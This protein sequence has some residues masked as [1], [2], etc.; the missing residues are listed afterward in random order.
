M[1]PQIAIT[2]NIEQ[3][4]L[5]FMSKKDNKSKVMSFYNNAK[6]TASPQKESPLE[7]FTSS[8]IEGS[9]NK[10]AVRKSGMQG[11][12][13]KYDELADLAK[14]DRRKFFT[15]A[16][17]YGTMLSKDSMGLMTEA[18]SAYGQ[19]TESPLANIALEIQTAS[20]G[21]PLDA[22][23][24]NALKTNTPM[25][26]AIETTKDIPDKIKESINAVPELLDAFKKGV[27]GERL[28]Q[29]GDVYRNA[30]FPEPAA[31]ALGF[32][33]AALLDP[34]NLKRIPLEQA[35]AGIDD[36]AKAIVRASKKAKV[37]QKGVMDPQT[38]KM[39]VPKGKL[40]INYIERGKRIKNMIRNK[41]ANMNEQIKLQADDAINS[42]QKESDDLINKLDDATG[43]DAIETQDN[44]LKWQ[45][46]NSQIYGEYV[47]KI[48]GYM[49]KKGKELRF[50]DVENMTNE[51]FTSLQKEGRL[52]QGKGLDALTE[53]MEKYSSNGRTLLRNK[54]INF[55]EFLSDY[56]RVKNSIDI[57]TLTGKLTPES[58]PAETFRK[59][60]STFIDT[61]APGWKALNQRYAAVLDVTEKA[62]HIFKQGKGKYFAEQGQKFIQS[63]A[64]DAINSIESVFVDDLE[65]GI[66]GFSSGLGDIAKRS[67]YL[68][69]KI[70][71]NKARIGEIKEY[72]RLLQRTTA[73]GR[74][75]AIQRAD[76]KKYGVFGAKTLDSV[77]KANIVKQVAKRVGGVIGYATL[78][79]L[80]NRSILRNIIGSP[81]YNN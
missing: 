65:K 33:T 36:A 34:L 18:L 4:V 24:E 43:L 53:F 13:E 15:R 25:Q 49:Q 28:G 73:K 17:D 51:V 61:K 7:K 27:T 40:R 20:A 67:T 68:A 56:K 37:I 79:A 58:L 14:T 41:Y 59:I 47:D 44:L 3:K 23:I 12:K 74:R 10:I 60:A 55:K 62:A 70:G 81:N 22:V 42:I 63:V 30:G 76:T 66:R 6:P 19:V 46:K 78:Y 11:I 52:I 54:F 39:L 1:P 26:A 77:K 48:S 8:K 45:K 80:I 72:A 29:Y 5:S 2:P 21:S 32:T 64:E 71:D 75:T 31:A 50:G 35:E 16:S 38:G 57:D 69:K 9:E